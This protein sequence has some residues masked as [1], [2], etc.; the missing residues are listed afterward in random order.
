MYTW[1]VWQILRRNEKRGKGKR[2]LEKWSE[3]D[4]LPEVGLSHSSEE[5]CES[6]WS[7]GDNK[8]A[9]SNGKTREIQ[10]ICK[11]WNMN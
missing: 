5:A 3:P 1:E 4:S 10:E 9:F 8:S 7:E 2:S 11:T 6:M